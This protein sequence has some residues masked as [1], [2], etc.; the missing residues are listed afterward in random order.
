[1]YRFRQPVQAV[2]A[3]TN[4]TINPVPNRTDMRGRLRH[5][6][7]VQDASNEMFMLMLMGWL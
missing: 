5:A 3:S 2:R 7:A 6:V 1:M 4:R